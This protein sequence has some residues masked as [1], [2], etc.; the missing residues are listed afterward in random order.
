[1]AP[2]ASP[3]TG[4]GRAWHGSS[5]SGRAVRSAWSAWRSRRRHRIPGPHSPASRSS[6]WASPTSCR[7][8]SVLRASCEGSR[9]RTALPQRLLLAAWLAL[10]PEY[11]DRRALVAAATFAAVLAIAQAVVFSL[12]AFDQIE[13][14][15]VAVECAQ[16][17]A[18][19]PRD[20]LGS[21]L[22]PDSRPATR[23]NALLGRRPGVGRFW[24]VPVSSQVS[25]SAP[26][27]ERQ[28]SGK[29][30]GEA[31]TRSRPEAASLVMRRPPATPPMRCA[32]AP[33]DARRCSS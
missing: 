15:F 17:P 1:M 25:C 30:L 26:Q 13:K 22:A 21:P 28:A 19:R 18:R 29:A 2:A 27:H 12:G 20:Q 9:Q 23:N 31:R 10:W 33:R 11:R 24:P 8:C 16:P 14:A 3:A 4:F 5:C 7:C 6:D 32:G